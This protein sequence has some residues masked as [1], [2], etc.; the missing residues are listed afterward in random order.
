[1]I[2]TIYNIKDILQYLQEFLN[3]LSPFGLHPKEHMFQNS[4]YAV[5]KFEPSEHVKWHKVSDKIV[6]GQYNRGDHPHETNSGT[7]GLY[8]AV[9][10][11]PTDLPISIKRLQFLIKI[12]FVH[13]INKSQD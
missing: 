12:S 9:P 4:Y 6:I 8:S 10:M 13:K 1:L 11:I 7:T 2:D 3:F 5:K